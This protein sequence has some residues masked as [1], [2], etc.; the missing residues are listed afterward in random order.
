V[1]D[2]VTPKPVELRLEEISVALYGNPMRAHECPSAPAG[3]LERVRWLEGQLR[4]LERRLG[5]ADGWDE[6]RHK[7][8]PPLYGSILSW[9]YWHQRQQRLVHEGRDP[10]GSYKPTPDP[11]VP[12]PP[13][14]PRPLLEAV[15]GLHQA[16][17]QVLDVLWSVAR[18]VLVSEANGVRAV[19]EIQAKASELFALIEAA[20]DGV[21]PEAT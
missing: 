13:T 17:G 14:R 9:A 4:T 21:K 7:S 5:V 8:G 16:L 19:E 12:V 1:T 11:T 3:L 18:V 20:R 2:D 15:A 10:D 6:S